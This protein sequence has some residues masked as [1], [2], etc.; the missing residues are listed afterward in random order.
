[1]GGSAAFAFSILYGAFVWAHR[2]RNG[3]KRR[4][5]ARAGAQLRELQDRVG[6]LAAA[7]E[8]ARSEH[9]ES[10]A[11]MRT[12]LRNVQKVQP[13]ATAAL[14][15]ELGAELDAQS[16]QQKLSSASPTHPVVHPAVSFLVMCGLVW[17]VLQLAQEHRVDTAIVVLV[18]LV[19][20]ALTAVMITTGDD[21]PWAVAS[22]QCASVHSWIATQIE[23]G[24]ISYAT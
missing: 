11:E 7:A 2:A 22:F 8:R 5:P 20:G 17:L 15:A 9:E 18:A 4:F 21:G 14:K 10:M 16:R 23:P 12:E 1:M 6:A 24:G 3:P 13:G 19:G